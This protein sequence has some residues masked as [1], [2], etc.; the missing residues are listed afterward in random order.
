MQISAI[1][2]SV[3]VLLLLA[4]FAGQIRAER[5]VHRRGLSYLH[6]L[7]FYYG[8]LTA[9][10]TALPAALLLL[11]WFVAQNSF[12]ET[13]VYSQ[14][15]GD[16]KFGDPGERDLILN[17]VYNIAYGSILNGHA[18]P[19][20]M[21][22]ADYLRSLETRGRWTTAGLVW[23]SMSAVFLTVMSKSS[24]NLRA[25]S[26]VES[27]F[28]YVFF[29][30]AFVALLITGGILFSVLFEALL[31]F[32]AVPF[33]EFIFGTEWRPQMPLHAE[34]EA[35]PARFGAAPLF[36]GTLV[37]AAIALSVA[38]PMGLMSAIYLAEYCSRSTRLWVKPLL[39][40]L[41]G[42]P[43]V[44]YG[45][46]VILV[47][48]PLLRSSLSWL[49]GDTLMVSPQSALA[50]GLVLGVMVVPFISSLADDALV[51]V[52]QSLR[53][54]ALA[55]GATR[56]EV[57]KQVL[58]PAAMPGILSGVLLAA[59]RALGETMIV[60]MAAGITANFT[61]NPLQSMT[62][63]TVQIK[64]LLEGDNAFDNPETLAAFA[65]GLTLFAVTLGFNLIAIRAA[66]KFDERY[67]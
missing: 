53:D 50:V 38:V 11:M 45:F 18:P 51:A 44:V 62:T 1:L 21:R 34:Q 15:P 60:V 13:L 17:Q 66:R 35:D 12:I 39:E 42:I 58:I 2:L 59:S 48:A 10:W 28:Q 54:G 26:I 40:V 23:V 43:S 67:G 19:E 22:A 27:I 63:V 8:L 9:L 36:V 14:V 25:R 29:I 7:P 4:Y 47:V 16:F 55:L 31:F 57:V 37:I 32:D 41:A 3:C 33:S 61:F 65:L 20:L 6:S 56:S 46:F 30:S 24:P 5:Q 52:P 64:S 49:S